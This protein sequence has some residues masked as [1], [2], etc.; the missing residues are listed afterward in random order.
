MAAAFRAGVRGY[1]C[2]NQGAQELTQAIN[3]VASGG[4]Y[5]SPQVSKLLLGAYL[6]G[7]TAAPNALT[8]REREVLQ[9]VAEGNTTKQ[10]ASALGLTTKTAESYRTRLMAKLDIHDTAGLVRYAIRH[11]V[12]QLAAAWCWAFAPAALS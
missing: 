5:L 8:L 2:K 6:S 12:I 4:T 9:L 7:S 1:V 10:V 11:G 3:E